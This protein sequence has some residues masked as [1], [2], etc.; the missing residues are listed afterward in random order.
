M[1]FL[2]DP[3]IPEWERKRRAEV[4]EVIANYENQIRAEW[5]HAEPELRR[6]I[7]AGAYERERQYR[8]RIMRI[9]ENIRTEMQYLTEQLPPYLVLREDGIL[10]RMEPKR[11]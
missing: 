11:T 2:L 6:M 1:R 3:E 8:S 9:T 10:E 7:K 5:S 4:C